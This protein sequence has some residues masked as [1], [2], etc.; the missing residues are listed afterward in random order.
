MLMVLPMRGDPPAGR[1][2]QAAR[3]QHRQKMLQPARALETAVCEQPVKTKIGAEQ[4]KH[5]QPGKSRRNAGPTEESWN[6]DQQREQVDA[7]NADHIQ[8]NNFGRSRFGGE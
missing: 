3:S 1:V 6:E 7:A 8:P 2:L 5:E 4:T